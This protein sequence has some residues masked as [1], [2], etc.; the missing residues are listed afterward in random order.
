M[1][2]HGMPV[3]MLVTSGPVA[4]CKQACTPIERLDEEYL[5]ADKSY[6]SDAVVKKVE[7]TGAT[8]DIPITQKSKRT[9]RL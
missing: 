1:N 2:A 5:L 6:D 9:T 7:E 8:A 4:D 3:R